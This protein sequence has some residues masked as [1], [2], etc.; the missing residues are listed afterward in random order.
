[1][2]GQLRNCLGGLSEDERAVVEAMQAVTMDALAFA[3]GSDTDDGDYTPDDSD[4]SDDSDLENSATALERT[5]RCGI[6][7][8]TM[9]KTMTS[10]HPSE[11]VGVGTAEDSDSKPT[12]K[13]ETKRK[14]T[15]RE[16][17]ELL[18]NVFRL[19]NQGRLKAA[20][21]A[22]A[23]MA[24]DTSSDE[25]SDEKMSTRRSALA[26]A[27]LESTAS[28]NASSSEPAA[29]ADPPTRL[30]R[31][32]ASEIV[33]HLFEV[34]SLQTTRNVVALILNSPV[35]RRLLP[36]CFT[37]RSKD[38]E[39]KAA[40][41][42]AARA[43]LKDVTLLGSNGKRT[44]EDR[45]AFLAAAAALM[46]RNL[47]EKRWGRAAQRSLGLS[48]RGSTS[49]LIIRCNMEDS[50]E[51]WKRLCDKPHSD[52][53]EGRFIDEWWH[54]DEASREDN[55][56]KRPI[57]IECGLS[58]DAGQQYAIHWKR[59]QLHTNNGAR[60]VFLKS[61]HYKRLQESHAAKKAEIAAKRSKSASAAAAK[62]KPEDLKISV[63]T[64]IRRRCKC[65]ITKKP[66]ECDCTICSPV[67]V[68]T[69]IWNKARPQ[70]FRQNHRC[71]MCR[72]PR[73][74]GSCIPGCAHDSPWRRA[75]HSVTE[76]ERSAMCPAVPVPELASNPDNV[77]M[78]FHPRCAAGQCGKCPINSWPTENAVE[79][80][81]GRAH[82]MA[83]LPRWAYNDKE[84][85]LPVYKLAFVSVWGTRKEFIVFIVLRIKIYLKHRWLIR[86]QSLSKKRFE[87][88]KTCEKVTVMED[89]AA[90]LEVSA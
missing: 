39:F 34:G 9:T 89:F 13:H 5:P 48:W 88:K 53:L 54:S 25:K 72:S 61:D 57:N 75:S 31:L 14:R 28:A 6:G 86:M 81:G 19:D 82:W 11:A 51:G 70:W 17:R 41:F 36:T 21:A 84:T 80:A 7:V 20:D 63:K 32:R 49:A 27:E 23:A 74:Y 30:E 26:N 67:D 44:T 8:Q 3:D 10:G 77:P 65:A 1:M 33:D 78:M 56:D 68:N 15:G 4:D 18:T 42:E 22:F 59:T 85:G 79:S 2:L 73:C 69:F 58:E 52:R 55:S 66:G 62:R 37:E 46:P 40:A 43:M 60:E 71:V 38:T 29:P 90:Q 64:L 83:W 50:C 76:L 45:N 16:L 24:M 12:A 87:A 47:H 35:M